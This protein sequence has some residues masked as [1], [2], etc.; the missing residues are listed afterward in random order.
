[1][2]TA[3]LFEV[4]IFDP[5]QPLANCMPLVVSVKPQAEEALA[6]WLLRFAA[7]FGIPA[8]ILLL[9]RAHAELIE[10]ADWW[11]RPDPRLLAPLA[12]R[13]GFAPPAIAAM[14]NAAAAMV[15]FTVAILRYWPGCAAGATGDLLPR[16]FYCVVQ[17]GEPGAA[18]DC[19]RRLSPR[20]AS[21]KGVV[22][23]GF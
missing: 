22:R 1:M 18:G 5:P 2:S 21:M 4:E 16:P 3:N 17:A 8:E 10:Q 11:R 12:Q 15:D 9:D 7:P 13:T 14:S 23:H 19:I 20:L 6:S